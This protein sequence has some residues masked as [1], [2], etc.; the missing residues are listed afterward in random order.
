MSFIL[1]ALRKSEHRRQRDVGPGLVD[2]PIARRASR[3]PLILGIL[4]ALLAINLIVLGVVLLRKQSPEEAAKPPPAPVAAAPA[5]QAVTSIAGAIP[6]DPTLSREVR[7]LGEEATQYDADGN[8]LEPEAASSDAADALP[9]ELLPPPV[10]PRERVIGSLPPAAVP[11]G[12]GVTTGVPSINDLTPQATSGLPALNVDLHVY[13]RNAAQRFVVIN[14]QR[15]Q[16]GAV[17][18]EGPTV[19]RITEEG[20][21]LNHRGLRFLLPHQ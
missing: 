17:L 1:D 8:P 11:S 12:G 7:P 4:G 14:G 5:P 10:P 19:E 21:V 18:K 2:V 9:T 13:A 15:Y 3:L 16:E 20:V 6:V